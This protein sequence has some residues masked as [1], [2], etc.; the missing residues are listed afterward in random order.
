MRE[1]KQE[2]KSAMTE[3]CSSEGQ[4]PTLP[5]EVSEAKLHKS[6]QARLKGLIT[7]TLP[8]AVSDKLKG[9]TPTPADR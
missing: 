2:R 6:S 4:T 1:R 3:T 7:P 9:L 5:D 8:D